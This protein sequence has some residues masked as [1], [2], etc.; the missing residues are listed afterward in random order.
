MMT[1]SSG[2]ICSQ[3][4]GDG[5]TMSQEFLDVLARHAPAEEP[6]RLDKAARQLD[7]LSLRLA[8]VLDGLGDL[9]GRQEIL[10]QFSARV[11]A[12]L[13]QTNGP[14]PLTPTPELLEWARGLFSD[15]EIVAGLREIRETGGLQLTDFIH[16]LEQEATSRE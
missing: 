5:A 2:S 10:A 15:E 13:A 7:T 6:Q 12:A 16:E 1:I 9:S 3:G 14:R 4:N 11:L 8:A